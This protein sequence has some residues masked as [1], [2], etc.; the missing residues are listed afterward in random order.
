M[1]G[2]GHTVV[3][4]PDGLIYRAMETIHGQFP[5]GY[6][7]YTNFGSMIFWGETRV[8]SITSG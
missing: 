3:G 8:Y 4:D 5:V 7:S 6:T 2:V 1:T